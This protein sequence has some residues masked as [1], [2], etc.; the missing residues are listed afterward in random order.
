MYDNR[1][2]IR[3]FNNTTTAALYYKHRDLECKW[4]RCPKTGVAPIGLLC[5]YLALQDWISKAI[6]I[7]VVD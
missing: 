2:K 7:S 3:V 4:E 1:Y 6:M 5:L